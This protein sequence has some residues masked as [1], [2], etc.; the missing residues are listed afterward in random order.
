MK[1]TIFTPTAFKH[2]YTEAV[3]AD[4]E[5]DTMEALFAS[6]E[7]AGAPEGLR[8]VIHHKGRAHY[9]R[10]NKKWVLVLRTHE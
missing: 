1:A 2:N 8:V 10:H 7:E 5:F 9:L 3:S 4:V 6:L